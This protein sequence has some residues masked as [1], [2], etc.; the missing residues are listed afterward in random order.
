MKVVCIDRA[1]FTELNV[2]EIY[3]GEFE[4]TGQEI[5]IYQHYDDEVVEEDYIGLYPK[6]LFVDEQTYIQIQRDK[7]IE[8]ICNS[9]K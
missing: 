1:F 6:E 4:S 7:K 8:V 3:D 9:Q 2:G 5:S